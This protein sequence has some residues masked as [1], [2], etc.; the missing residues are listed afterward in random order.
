[1]HTVTLDYTTNKKM[2]IFMYLFK[3]SHVNLSYN[4]IFVIAVD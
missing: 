3:K 1:M 2:F 4:A